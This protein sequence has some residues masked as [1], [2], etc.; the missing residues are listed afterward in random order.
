M[1]KRTALYSGVVFLLAAL[2]AQAADLVIGM[3]AAVDNPDPHQ[4][5]TPNRNVG[6]QV[7]EPLIY[8]DRYLKPEPWLATEWKNLNPTTW[9]LRLREGVKFSNGQ[10]FTA[11][12]VVFS[13]D[14]G[15]SIEGLRTYRS[16]LKDIAKVEALD[17]FTVRITTKQP[18]TLL[19]WNLT[20]IGMV[21][22]K[23]ADGATEADFNGGKAAVGTGPY[24]WIK[25]TPGQDVVL[26][27]NPSYWNGVEP[28][29][30]VTFRFI[31]NDSA[32]VAALLSGDVDVI[33]QVPGNLARKIADDP[34][35]TL[36]EDTSVFNAFLSMDRSRDA[37]PFITGSD[38]VPLTRNPFKD[39]KVREAVN[40]AIN[41]AGIAD[42][43]MH[44]S[45]TPTGQ[46]SPQGMQGN[47]PAIEIPKYDPARAKALLAEAGYPQGF[48]VTLHCFNDRF[49]GDAQVCQAI[50]SMFTA[51]GIKTKVDTMPST[52]FYKRAASGGPDGSPEF[53]MFMAVYGTPTGNS[54]N[55]LLNVIHSSD[56]AR[57][58]GANNRSLYSNPSVDKLIDDSQ[59]IFDAEEANRK[60]LEATKA[61]LQDSAILPLFFLKS[62]WGTKKGI[63]LEPRGDGFTM[64]RGIRKQ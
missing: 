19:P 59:T 22:A 31:A 12:D 57:G 4:L 44:G 62:S 55:L 45:A 46:I 18:T 51:I 7:Y 27:K 21:S 40:I 39:A 35:T 37:S 5:F 1:K 20:S 16:Y 9:E 11:D 25:W 3:K 49:A 10:P 50:A 13:L 61:G 53:S 26:E 14:R 36:V 17:P 29:D 41:R 63:S 48:G 30:K 47:D 64:A 42:R 15:L 8:Q 23:A 24:K 54:S 33:D 58:L 34:K 60:L 28:W 43:I 2:S 56:K 38:G 52:V 6:L 32:R